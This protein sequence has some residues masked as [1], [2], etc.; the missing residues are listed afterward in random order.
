MRS[1]M[2]LESCGSET[3]PTPEKPPKPFRNTW[4]PTQMMIDGVGSNAWDSP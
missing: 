4:P 1:E 2:C 3:G